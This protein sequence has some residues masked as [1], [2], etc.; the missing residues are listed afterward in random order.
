MTAPH[1]SS[2]PGIDFAALSDVGMKRPMNQ[3]AFTSSC[4]GSTSPF[5]VVADGMGAHA[6]GELASQIA[7]Q[8]VESQLREGSTTATGESL[9]VAIKTANAAIY[10]QGQQDT[11]LYNMGTTCTTVVLSPEGAWVGHVGDSR[12]YRCRE[13]QIQQL[14][15]DHSL[16]WEMR[17]AGQIRVS[18]QESGVPR[19]VITRCLGPHAEVEADIEGPFSIR[20]G[21]VFLLCSDGLTGRVTDPEIGV[22]AQSLPPDE[23]TQ[24]LVDLA[25]LRGGSDNVTVLIARTTD[26]TLNAPGSIRETVRPTKPMG[27]HPGWWFGAAVGL[28]AVLVAVSMGR[29]EYALAGGAVFLFSVLGAGFQWLRQQEQDGAHAVA[30]YVTESA[31]LDQ[32]FLDGILE[33]VQFVASTLSLDEE[34]AREVQ[35]SRQIEPSQA[36]DA[37]RH[38]ASIARHLVQRIRPESDGEPD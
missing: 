15:F 37:C 34:L 36:G 25:N 7:V 8:E 38:L 31:R 22:I 27:T 26:A 16:V 13:S 4:D 33:T 19:N 14:T 35:A 9:G 28:G 30:P 23:A 20:Q 32:D 21:D 12:A 1:S 2:H 5:F 24:F 10:S 18:D 29:P 6:A 11:Q 17:A 3:D